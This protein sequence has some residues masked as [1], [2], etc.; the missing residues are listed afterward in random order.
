[1]LP[2]TVSIFFVLWIVHKL[3]CRRGPLYAPRTVQQDRAAPPSA[4]PR[5][6]HVARIC[7]HPLSTTTCPALH[8]CRGGG[9]SYSEF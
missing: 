1:M 9:Y 7:L 2:S 6:P 8:A 5:A 3:F 4:A